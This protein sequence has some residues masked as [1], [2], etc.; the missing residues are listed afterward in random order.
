[1]RACARSSGPAAAARSQTLNS[2]PYTGRAAR[3]ALLPCRIAPQLFRKA[4]KATA[5]SSSVQ[6]GS[7]ANLRVSNWA[8][9][10]FTWALAL[11][12]FAVPL[13]SAGSL[14][15][16][17]RQ[18]PTPNVAAKRECGAAMRSLP[19]F[20]SD[21]FPVRIARRH[22]AREGPHVGDVGDLLGIAVDDVAGFV[23]RRRH[24]LGLEADRHLNGA[25][26][27]FGGGDLG[28]VDRHETAFHGVAAFFALGDR[29]LEAVIDFAR[30]QIFQG[31]AITF[32]KG[33]DDH[34]IGGAR[35]GEEMLG[36][37][38]R[39]G[40]GDRIKPGGDGRAGLCLLYTSPS[41]RDGL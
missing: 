31:A 10:S 6:P 9:R 2:A 20:G 35:A 15:P 17:I 32:G 26:A 25:A 4:S 13:A 23:A 22:V 21:Q 38:I 41:P 36:V 39:R 14:K 40:G 7:D 28:I 11:R 5:W 37:E 30:Q 34:L 8:L 19:G 18:R 27:R 3:I 29:G 24:Q 33:V 1:M 12:C 16:A